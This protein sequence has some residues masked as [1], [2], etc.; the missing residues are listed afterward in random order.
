MAFTHTQRNSIAEDSEFGGLIA[1]ALQLDPTTPVRYTDP[2]QIPV[3][4]QAIIAAH[5]EVARDPN[6]NIYGISTYVNGEIINPFVTRDFANGASSTGTSI[7]DKFLGDV[8]VEISP[9]QGLTITSRLGIDNAWQNV[10]WWNPVYYYDDLRY[11]EAPSVNENID[12]WNTWQWENF[13]SYTKKI[14]DHDFSVMA[15]MSSQQSIHRTTGLF[16]SP[17]AVNQESYSEF[18][19]VTSQILIM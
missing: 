6:G 8:F 16:A 12:Y 7:Q 4:V 19:Y 3:D 11:N 10:H 17:M 13:A 2:S 5:P 15:G 18:N 9:I 14:G 1:D